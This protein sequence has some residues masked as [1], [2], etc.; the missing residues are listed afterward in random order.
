MSGEAF[1]AASSL[2]SMAFG[3]VW[4]CEYAHQQRWG[5]CWMQAAL[6][7]GSAFGAVN[8]LLAAVRA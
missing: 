5:W 7:I 8:N 2:L 1:M 3:A 6:A 4:A